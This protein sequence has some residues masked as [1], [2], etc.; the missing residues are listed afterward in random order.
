MGDSNTQVNSDPLFNVVCSGVRRVSTTS[1]SELTLGFLDKCLYSRRDFF[2][3]LW[4]HETIRCQLGSERPV[5]FDAVK[6]CRPIRDENVLDA[7]VL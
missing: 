4:L 2:G 7:G 3:I 5:R 6:V 1:H